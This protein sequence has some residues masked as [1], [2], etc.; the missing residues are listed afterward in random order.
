[1]CKILKVSKSKYYNWLNKPLGNRDK[2]MKELD[3]M[4]RSIFKE[5]KE[6]YGSTRIYHELKAQGVAC[7]R[8]TIA[9]RMQKMNLIA[10]A[11]K[12]FKV[13]TD[14][15]HKLRVA[16]NILNQDFI[17]TSPNEKWVSDISYIPSNEGWL[18]LCVF[19]DLYS[20]SII[21]WSIQEHLRA[22]LVTNALTMALFRRKFPSDVI[23]HSDRGSQY[24]SKKYQ[25]L[26]I[27]NNM[28]CSMSGKGSCYD[29]SP[30]ESFFHTL[31]VELVHGNKYKTR[32]EAK[33]S[34]ASYIECYYNKKR[35]HSGINYHIP[36]EYEKLKN[37]G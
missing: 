26:L 11:R 29:N 5:H 32:Q 10:K 21:G 36:E 25:S 31:K 16:G 34:I 14:S 9:S 12:K 15:N 2:R 13:T 24:C 17:T 19:M 35:R 3:L 7:T 37:V 28:I 20:R 18:Y 22:E 1:M 6:R 23:I 8:S 33:S 4:I 30:A 27:K